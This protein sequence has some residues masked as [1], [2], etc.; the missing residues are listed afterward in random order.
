MEVPSALISDSDRSDDL[1]IQGDL[2]ALVPGNCCQHRLHRVVAGRAADLD[3]WMEAS[4][5]VE[6]PDLHLDEVLSV[7]CSRLLEVDVHS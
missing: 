3:P 5:I 6:S 2:V 1:P 7:D 4:I